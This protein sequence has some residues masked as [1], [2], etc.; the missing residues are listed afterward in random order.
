MVQAWCLFEQQPLITHCTHCMSLS[1]RPARNLVQ[2]APR[3]HTDR[4]QCRASHQCLRA[5]PAGCIGISMF[6]HV[7]IIAIHADV[8]CGPSVCCQRSAN[9]ASPQSNPRSPI[10]TYRACICIVGKMALAACVPSPR[11][12]EGCRTCGV[13]RHEIVV[14]RRENRQIDRAKA[15]SRLKRGT[16]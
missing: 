13:M 14:W 5:R 12:L 9:R 2:Y 7:C 10:R 6:F 16:H 15:A 11:K 3:G 8:R 1:P 4:P